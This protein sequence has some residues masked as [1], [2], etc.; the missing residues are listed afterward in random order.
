M[1]TFLTF[2]PIIMVVLFILFAGV[3]IIDDARSPHKKNK[4]KHKA[5]HRHA[6]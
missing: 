4:S 3:L 5:S 1:I 6:H 2:L